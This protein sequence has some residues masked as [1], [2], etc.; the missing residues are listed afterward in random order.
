MTQLAWTQVVDDPAA[1]HLVAAHIEPKAVDEPAAMMSTLIEGLAPIGHFALI[2]RCEAE[3][4]VMLCAFS[5][6]SDAVALAYA[7]GAYDTDEYPDWASRRSFTLDR[8]TA[9]AIADAIE[10]SRMAAPPLRRAA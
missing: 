1:R 3:G 6:P 4:P 10:A 9:Q 2:T 8:P 7:V 5:H